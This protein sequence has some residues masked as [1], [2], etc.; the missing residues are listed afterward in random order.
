MSVFHELFCQC[1]QDKL[2]AKLDEH[3]ADNTLAEEEEVSYLHLFSNK[4]SFVIIKVMLISVT[5]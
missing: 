3:D 5:F 1:F 4:P 2:L